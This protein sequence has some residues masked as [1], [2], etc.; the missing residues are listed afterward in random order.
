MFNR[1][2]CL[3]QIIQL[4]HN[5]TTIELE[6]DKHKKSAH[7]A[8][9]RLKDMERDRKEVVDE[10]ISLKTNYLAMNKEIKAMVS[11]YNVCVW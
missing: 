3:F 4:E 8:K 5:V 11:I 7:N 2:T 9:E 6:R 1:W 10:Y